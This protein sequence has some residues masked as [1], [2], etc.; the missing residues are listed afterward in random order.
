[1]IKLHTFGPA[2]GLPDGSPFVLK[3]MVLLKMS[4]LPFEEVRADVR[5]APK[6]KLPVI[7]DDGVVVPD[8]T[9]IR[10]H[11]EKAHGI[12]FDAGYDAA[13]LGAAW[14]VEKLLEDHLYW[15]VVQDRW[16]VDENFN[17]GPARLFRSIPMPLRLFVMSMVRKKIRRNLVGQGIGRHTDAERAELARRGIGAVAAV[18]GDRPYLLG[19]RPCGADATLFG[20]MAGALSPLFKSPTRDITEGHANLVAYRDRMFAQYFPG[21][22]YD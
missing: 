1:M 4:Q 6:G 3:T 5:K 8:S 21:F 12:D 20:F 18:L 11:L 19:D 13:A 15:L 17:K 10:L 14:A 9:F 2:F 16:M 22:K 7:D